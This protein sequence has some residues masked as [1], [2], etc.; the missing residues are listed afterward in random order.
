[1]PDATYQFVA[2]GADCCSVTH[3]QQAGT[4]DRDDAS[5]LA[6]RVLSTPRSYAIDCSIALHLGHQKRDDIQQSPQPGTVELVI[7]CCAEFS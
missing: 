7:R 4:R 2:C 5:Y 6:N 3:L 1:M